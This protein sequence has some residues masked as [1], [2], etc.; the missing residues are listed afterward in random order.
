[1]SFY[2]QQATTKE[3]EMLDTYVTDFLTRQGTENLLTQ[4]SELGSKHCST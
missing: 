4:Q 2:P 3:I 1:M